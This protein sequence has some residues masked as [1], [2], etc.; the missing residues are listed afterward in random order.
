MD[1]EARERKREE[2]R[3]RIAA[4]KAAEAKSASNHNDPAQSVSDARDGESLG[5]QRKTVE[6]LK[7]EN[8]QDL[9]C[10]LIKA[11]KFANPS[12]GFKKVMHD[13]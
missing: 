11:I 13:L 2:I 7:Y 4:S 6:N 12:W 1:E 3:A 10:A 9:L 8:A 5:A